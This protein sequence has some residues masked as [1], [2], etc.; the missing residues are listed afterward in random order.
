MISISHATKIH[1]LFIYFYLQYSP[2]KV[3]VLQ[4]QNLP[5]HEAIFSY[6]IFQF[7]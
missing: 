1:E 7:N 4:M 3:S 5:F 2:G 6:P